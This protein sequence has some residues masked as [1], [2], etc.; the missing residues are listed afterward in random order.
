MDHRKIPNLALALVVIASLLV[1]A[2]G[3]TSAAVPAPDV[4]VSAIER[5]ATRQSEITAAAAPTIPTDE[6]QV[7]HYFGPYPNWANS[8]FTLPDVAVTITGDGSGRDGAARS[9]RTAPSPASP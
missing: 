6:T 8:P 9:G 2:G 5:E 4:A 3:A 7:P 1:A